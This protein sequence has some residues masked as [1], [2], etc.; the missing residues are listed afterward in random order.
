MRILIFILALM[1]AFFVSK[2]NAFALSDLYG[3]DLSDLLKPKHQMEPCEAASFNGGGDLTHKVCGGPDSEGRDAKMQSCM[4]LAA[5]VE[6]YSTEQYDMADGG[7]CQSENGTLKIFQS[8][9]R[10]YS[11]GTR[12]P[13][14]RTITVFFANIAGEYTY[15]CPPSNSAEHTIEVSPDPDRGVPVT[16]DDSPFWCAKPKEPEDCP[17][18]Y[19]SRGT[20]AQ[21]GSSG[22]IPKDCPAQGSS[23][24][25]Y[26][27]PNLGQSFNGAGL[28]CNGGCAYTVNS[29]NIGKSNKHAIGLSQGV[30]CGDKP[31]DTKK[32]ADEG[33][34]GS[35]TVTKT[36]NSNINVLNCP[37]APDVP[38]D[39]PH[40][41]DENKVDETPNAQK[42]KASCQA[43]D[44]ICHLNN[45]EIEIENS[46][47]RH[48]DNDNL[49]H[50]K[51]TEADTK[52]TNAIIAALGD[53]ET[54]I[55]FHRE[56]DERNTAI[57]HGKLQGV[58]DA[59]NGLEISGGGGGGG[60]GTVNGNIGGQDCEGTIEEC[61][62]IGSGDGV[63]LPTETLNLNQYADKYD[64]WLPNAELPEEKCVTL[65]NGKTLCFTYKYIILIF[66]AI[67]GLLVISAL[68]HSGKIIA[69]SF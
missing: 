4:S 34:E 63:E 48:M 19:H 54:Q 3:P 29:E 9:V 66:Q 60:N 22:C 47:N 65:T 56:D 44:S 5:T 57:T 68:I 58:I 24:E 52:N 36:G 43:G 61:A 7:T 51:Q 62:G 20:S 14:R 32:L 27:S 15:S 50:N 49:L 40:N 42:N 11:D 45:V 38:E 25:L 8:G 59:I 13:T 1:S 2:I 35:C 6:G 53:I 31:Y 46:T 16:G 12:L 17:A 64:D 21:L 69:G 18:G 10:K 33:D 23:K 37:S 67:S 41:N 30:A 55:Y 28:Y 26:T 39:T